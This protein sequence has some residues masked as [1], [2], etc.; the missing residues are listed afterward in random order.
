MELAQLRYFCDV[1]RTEH[2]TRS[3]QR[4]HVA[5]P[6]LTRAMH[7]LEGELGVTLFEHAGRNIRLTAEGARLEER[8]APL[9]ASLDEAVEEVQGLAVERQRVVRV[10]LLSASAVVVDAIAAFA[11]QHGEASFELTQD[12]DDDRWDV[13]VDTV[14]EGAAALGRQPGKARPTPADESLGAVATQASLPN[15]T[16]AATSGRPLAPAAAEARFR[17]AIGVAVPSASPYDSPVPLATLA[18]ERFIS[19]AGSR[20]FRGLCDALGAAHGFF[21]TVGFDSDSPAVVKKMIGLGLGVGFWPEHSW[22]A[23]Q[24]SGARWVR[25]AEKGFERTLAVSL[26]ARA[27]PEGTAAAFH[28]FLVEAMERT[29]EG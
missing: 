11:E 26:S 27:Q 8:I 24:G 16:A 17:E 23:L 12:G 6:A 2:M 19:L 29:W 15:R 25:L 13:R 14:L 3:A 21:P 10:A 28:R 20:R 9:L 22:G 7:R 18:D 4:L 5:Q 1:A